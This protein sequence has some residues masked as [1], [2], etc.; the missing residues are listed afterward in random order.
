MFWGFFLDIHIEP[1][2][3]WMS[4]Q[5]RNEGPRMTSRFGAL[6]IG[7]MAVPL[8]NMGKTDGD[9]REL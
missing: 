8:I 2:E 4:G 7:R 1:V 6:K 3:E 5:D 9:C